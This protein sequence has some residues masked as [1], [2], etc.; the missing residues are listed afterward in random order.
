MTDSL[1]SDT[2]ATLL[3]VVLICV[4][5]PASLADGGSAPIRYEIDLRQ[6]ATHLVRVR[7]TVAEAPPSLQIQFPAWNALYQI[8]DFVRDVQNLEGTCDGVPAGLSPVDIDTWRT[9]S[10]PCRQL[11]ISYRV[12]ANEESV[13]SAVLDDQHAF[14]NLA[15]ALFYLPALRGRPVTVRFLLPDGWKLVTPLRQDESG[16]DYAARDYD[17]LVDSP[18]EAGTFDEYS[19]QQRGAEFRVVV[20][21]DGARYPS[22]RLLE[23]LEKIT[24]TETG[25][26]QDVP[27]RRYTFILHFLPSGG[28]GMEH[29]FGSAVGFSPD[30]LG[31]NWEELEATLAHEFFHLWN[32]KRIRPQGLEPID[33]VHGNDT[34]D[35]WFSEGITST[36]QE[37]VLERSRLI[38]REG[39]YRR[40]AAKI[41]DLEARPARHFESAELSGIDAWLEGFPDYDRPG[42]SISYYDKGE[43]L[44]FLLDLGMR[45]ASSGSASLDDLMRALNRDFAKQ[46]RF[47][48]DSDLIALVGRLTGYRFDAASFFHDYVTG[49]RDLDYQKYLAYAGLNLS[50][51]ATPVADWGFRTEGGYQR[52]VRVESVES[53]SHA[54]QAGIQPGDVITAL[55]GRPLTVPPERLLGAKPGQK[56]ELQVERRSRKMTLKLQLE[57]ASETHYRIAENPQAPPDAVRLRNQW[58][59]PESSETSGSPAELNGATV[60]SHGIQ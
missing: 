27:F 25:L 12:Y 6:P 31:S 28:G 36:Y 3:L 57:A 43:L 46:G 5:S 51:V 4:L 13:F 30:E 21:S 40:L 16:D 60:E 1:W 41:E 19:Y 18:V 48:Q 17:E 52:P 44:G 2:K 24:A 54:A 49:T 33:Y 26:M 34:R 11:T 20:Y 59:S 29:A 15:Q 39:F 38:G 47:F 45:G 35:L 58:L 42:R 37:L 9:G 55:D 22:K 8:R 53:E 50:E 32:V 14:L 56:V 7:M 23:S 10:Q